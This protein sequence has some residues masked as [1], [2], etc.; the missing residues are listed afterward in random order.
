[1]AMPLEHGP[2]LVREQIEIVDIHPA[3]GPKYAHTL[4]DV[5]IPLPLIKMHED[6]GGVDE[7]D[8]LRQYW[9]KIIAT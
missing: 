3:S 1:M 6:N 8:T 7:I 5:A 2:S 4:G 9:R